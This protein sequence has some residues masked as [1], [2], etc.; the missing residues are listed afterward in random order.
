M[1]PSSNIDI[2][3]PFYNI[4][5]KKINVILYA[6]R[7]IGT[8]RGKSANGLMM[9]S[10]LFNVV[11]IIDKHAVGKDTAKVC[12]GV[13]ISVPIYADLQDALK[14][15]RAKAL[16][17]LQEPTIA[18]IEEV[19]A[20]LIHGLD[21][22]NTSF[23]FIKD[24]PEL[25]E[26]VA[27]YNC[28]YFDLR[29]VTKQQAYPNTEILN[30]KAKVVFVTGTDCGLGKRTA[31]YELTQEARKRGINAT[32]YAT[33]QTGLM[34][35]ENGTV[36]DSLIIEFS[37]GV[38]SQHVTQ[39]SQ[40]AY[41]LIFVEGQS[42]IF[43][44]ANSAMSLALLHGANPDCLIIV[45]DETRKQ[46]KGFDEES[47]L[48]KMH[49]LQKHIDTL[50]MLSL[51]CGPEYTTVG[52]ATIGNDNVSNIKDILR[53]NTIPVADVR[54]DKGPAILLDSIIRFLDKRKNT[55]DLINYQL[56]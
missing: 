34:L 21:L 14:N 50:K 29:D 5:K 47:P 32:M 11:A 1:N 24:I 35:G 44:P 45:H 26:L 43:H 15:H 38:I 9:H 8:V 25:K 52:I 16:V 30:R 39:L 27:D 51:P 49:P 28:R 2:S 3:N 54:Q 40:Q 41:D 4:Y 17:F 23:L 6:D 31:A 7:L 13:R 19:R 55:S 10:K 36:I 22:I 20:A 18:S 37:N 46:H 53:D 48:Y 33:G 42:D 56:N 12:S